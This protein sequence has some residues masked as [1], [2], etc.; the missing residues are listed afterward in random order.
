M[1]PGNLGRLAV[2]GP[3]GCR[4]LADAR[5]KNYVQHGWN[6]TGDT[7]YLDAD[8]YFWFQ[9][10]A[11]D[12]IV[13][14][15]YNI[16]GPEVEWALLGHPAV[17]ECAVIGSPDPERGSIVKAFVVLKPEQRPDDAL[18]AA[19]Q[20]LVK[21][22]I[23]P[24]KYPRAHRVRRLAAE[25]ADRQTAA[26]CA[27][28]AGEGQPRQDL[29]EVIVT[30]IFPAPSQP[31]VEIK[32][33]AERFPVHRIYCVGRNYAAHAREMGKDPDREPPFFFTK[34]ADAV[35]ANGAT[36]P[37]P[38]RTANLHHEIELVV[39]HRQ[40]GRDIVPLRRRSS[41]VFGYAVGN[42]LT[43]RDLQAVA[44]DQGRPWDTRKGFDRSAPSARSR[45]PQAADTCAAA[46]SGS[47]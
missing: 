7:Y 44:K 27:A 24:Y 21:Q 13:S 39:A 1:P 10:R 30:F 43:R 23:A 37:Y 14:A 34:P 16:A 22:T 4:Y 28:G 46:G 3:T 45:P 33:R 17:R 32:G 18:R 29:R 42:D 2:K 5:Q 20:D 19:L 15:G 26:L 6:M 47:R 38:P 41:Y 25:D 40:G 11:D 12:M 8:G 35:V 36:I 9:A 31:S